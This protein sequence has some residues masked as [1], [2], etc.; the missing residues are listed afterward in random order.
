LLRRAGQESHFLCPGAKGVAC[1]ST[2]GVPMGSHLVGPTDQNCSAGP[3]NFAG[4]APERSVC[5]LSDAVPCLHK[6]P[7]RPIPFPVRAPRAGAAIPPRPRSL[8]GAGPLHSA[9]GIPHA[10]AI[11]HSLPPLRPG[12]RLQPLCRRWRGSSGVAAADRAQL[13]RGRNMRECVGI[14]DRGRAG[15]IERFPM[16]HET[17]KVTGIVV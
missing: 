12:R 10:L 17:I 16:C 5:N 2:P 1:T 8:T 13:R 9:G 6:G 15:L 4:C 14:A 11:G 3:L 7:L